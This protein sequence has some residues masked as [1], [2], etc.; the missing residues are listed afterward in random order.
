MWY[1]VLH[2]GGACRYDPSA[3]VHHYHRE[4]LPE[5][6]R[7]MRAYM[8]GHVVALLVQHAR[9]G[10]AGNL[11]RLF[12]TIP[13]YTRCAPR[14]RRCVASATIRRSAARSPARASGIGY[15]LR[16]RDQRPWPAELGGRP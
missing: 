12:V 8:R 7:Q 5:L 6:R 16:T 10:D 9:Y 11:Y 4:D 13:A 15:Y 14:A 2:A 3:V 1:R